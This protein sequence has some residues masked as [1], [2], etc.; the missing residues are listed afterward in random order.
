M[1]S[2]L[3]TSFT[4]SQPLTLLIHCFLFPAFDPAFDPL[5]SLY[6]G[7]LADDAMT[8]GETG[9]AR[10]GGETGPARTGGE[11]GPVRSGGDTDNW[12]AM[13]DGETDEWPA[14]GNLVFT[15]CLRDFRCQRTCINV[16]LFPN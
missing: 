16:N 1:V 3:P 4:K 5:L 9:P 6:K 12:P 2:L 13:T 10:I 11:T 7:S 8:G 14:R 15:M